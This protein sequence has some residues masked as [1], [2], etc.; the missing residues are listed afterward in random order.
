MFMNLGAFTVAGLIHRETGSEDINDYDGLARRNPIL[1]ICMAV[2]M[3]SLVGL[4]PFAGF[5]AKLN[6]MYVLGANGGWWWALVAVIGLN[7][8]FSLYYYARVIRVMYLKTSEKPAF[9]P[10]PLGMAL[11]GLC[12]A[13]LL[14]MFIGWN[15][16][17][18]LTTSYGRMYLTRSA[19][20]AAPTTAPTASI[21]L[22]P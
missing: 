13:M 11:A 5:A 20:P 4:P 15:P 21:A 12:A 16:L 8:I 1:A 10:N 3:F 17:N 22:N 19:A 14:I 9:M 2:F 7:T 18:R 6:V